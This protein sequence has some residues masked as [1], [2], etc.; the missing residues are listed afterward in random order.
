MIVHCGLPQDLLNLL[1]LVGQLLRPQ[2]LEETEH[3]RRRQQKVAKIV[4]CGE[5]IDPLNKPEKRPPA[6]GG[7]KFFVR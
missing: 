3:F 5:H 1:Y 6:K 2:D 7:L 4:Q